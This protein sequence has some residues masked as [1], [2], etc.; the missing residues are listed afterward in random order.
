MILEPNIDRRSRVILSS[1]YYAMIIRHAAER[2]IL[3]SVCILEEGIPS[4]F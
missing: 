1:G 3:D 4:V 2:R